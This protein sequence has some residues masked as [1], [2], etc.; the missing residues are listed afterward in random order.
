MLNNLFAKWA[1]FW[2]RGLHVTQCRLGIMRI[3]SKPLIVAAAV[4]IV[5]KPRVGRMTRLSASWFAQ[6][7]AGPMFCV[8]RQLALPLQSASRLQIGTELVGRNRGRRPIALGRQRFS[9]EAMRSLSVASICQHDVDRSAVLVA[10][11]K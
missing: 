9:Q 5:S 7:L 2:A 1:S 10:G 3:T 6:V 4:F 11:A 8:G